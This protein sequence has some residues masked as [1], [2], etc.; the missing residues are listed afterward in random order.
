MLPCPLT[1][2]NTHAYSNTYTHIHTYT[3]THT[4]TYTHTGGLYAAL[5][6]DWCHGDTSAKHV[7]LIA[8]AP[9]HGMAYHDLDDNYPVG[10][11]KGLV[12]EQLAERLMNEKG[13]KFWFMKINETTDKM[14][15]VINEHCGTHGGKQV[16]TITLAGG[17]DIA[18][19]FARLVT[20]AVISE[21]RS[22]HT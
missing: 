8:D 9:C 1:H 13:A 5:S 17:G 21:L 10:D 3:Y 4:R 18:A 12:I 22:H 7:F 11:P 20:Q 16:Q 2:S 14:I 6:L 15:N 19:E